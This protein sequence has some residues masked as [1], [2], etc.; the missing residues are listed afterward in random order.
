MIKSFVGTQCEWIREEFKCV[1]LSTGDMLRAAVA[2]GTEQGLQAKTFMDA[3]ALLPDENMISIILARLSEADCV[4][5]GWLLDGFPRTGAQADALA[6][7]GIECDSFIHLDVPDDILTERVTGRRLDPV[8]GAIYHMKFK[9]P[10][11]EE[12]AGRLEQR[13]DDTAEKVVPRLEAFHKN[14]AA[15]LGSFESKMFK[16]DGN[17]DAPVVWE[18][19]KAHLLTKL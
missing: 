12:V 13:S 15:V 8:T 10:P 17:R 4:E 3:G 11:D 19:I 2:A 9:P 7:A 14:L 16:I 6:S 5:R 1:H 18:E